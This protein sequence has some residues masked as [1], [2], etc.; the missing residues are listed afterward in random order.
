[1]KYLPLIPLIAALFLTGCFQTLMV[2]PG[3]YLD[4]A[5]FPPEPSPTAPAPLTDE[6]LKEIEAKNA[7]CYSKVNGVCQPN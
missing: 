3:Y 6:R 4:K 2:L 5:L 1:M 7:E